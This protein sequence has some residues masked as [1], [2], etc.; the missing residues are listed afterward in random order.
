MER[1]FLIQEHMTVQDA[2]FEAFTSCVTKS[3]VSILYE[4]DSNH[5]A[6][7]SRINHMIS[8]QN[9]N[10]YHYAQFYQEMC[11]FFDHHLGNDGKGWHRGVRPM[12][13]RHGGR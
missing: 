3:L 2:N 7:I 8:V 11:D 10:H 4:M 13:R 9:K 1:L 6:T 5:A 12:P